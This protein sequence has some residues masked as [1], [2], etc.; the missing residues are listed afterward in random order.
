MN[1]Q[2][3]SQTNKERLMQEIASVAAETE[4]LM[5]HAASAA[6]DQSDALRASVEKRFHELQDRFIALRNQVTEQ[7]RHAVQVT[8]TYVHDKPWQ[9]VGIAAAT[10][11]VVGALLGALIRR[12]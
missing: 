5:Q 9:A 2:V 7:T 1:A 10:G 11:L 4:Q 12:A 3:N 8:D 6:G